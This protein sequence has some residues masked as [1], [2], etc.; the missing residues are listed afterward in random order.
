MSLT[1]SCTR[2]SSSEGAVL[3]VPCC[4]FIDTVLHLVPV[5][6]V[7]LERNI[8]LLVCEQ[9]PLLPEPEEHLCRP[10]LSP[11][12]QPTSQAPGMFERVR[13]LT[14]VWVRFP[15]VLFFFFLRHSLLQLLPLPPPPAP[16]PPPL[17]LL[18]LLLWCC[19]C[20]CRCCCCCCCCRVVVVP[21]LLLLLLLLL[22]LLVAI[23]SLMFALVLAILVVIAAAVAVAVAVAV[24]T[25]ILARGF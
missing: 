18:L 4:S 22:V 23:V 24:A 2:S 1:E 25:R 13:V 10:M 21:L 15:L 9:G 19:C 14:L 8:C 20:C 5:A 11:L 3:A 17:L 16:P 6:R 7:I 12:T